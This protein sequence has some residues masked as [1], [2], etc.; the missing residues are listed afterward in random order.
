MSD[1]KVVSD[2]PAPTANLRAQFEM[3]KDLES[4]EERDIRISQATSAGEPRKLVHSA[5]EELDWLW[6]SC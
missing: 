4:Q 3:F 1:S 5:V 2:S 6:R